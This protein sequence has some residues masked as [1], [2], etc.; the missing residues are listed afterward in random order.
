MVKLRRFLWL[1][2]V[3]VTLFAAL[4]ALIG[5]DLATS[6]QVWAAQDGTATPTPRVATAEE[7]AAA[8][9]VWA[10]S[11]HADTFDGGLGA[12]TTCARCKSPTNWDYE[13][14]SAELALDCASC[15][16]VPGQPRP[17]LEGGIP[18]PESEWHNIG[19][20]VCHEPAGDS[21][22]TSI[23][24]WNNAEKRYEPM[25]SVQEL[26]AQCHEGRHGFE[27][28][29]E[30]IASAVHADWECTR[31]HGPHG[32]SATCED[33]HDVTLGTAVED[34]LRHE[35][36]NC[37]ACHDSGQLAVVLDTDPASRFYGTYVTERYAHTLTSWPSHNLQ[38]EVDCRRCHHRPSTTKAPVATE[39]GCAG[40]GCHEEGAVLHWCPLFKRSPAPEAETKR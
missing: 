1:V 28:I 3:L 39:V 12:N 11:A 8:Q 30:Q 10:D 21:F 37:T 13:A 33:C 18:V 26:C 4:M 19:C 32:E 5:V 17:E 22:M 24:Y 23:A 31:C 40:S 20:E 9:A 38:L 16:R 15:K 25:E 27:V 35:N 34:H 14:P 29:E 7:L 36:V 2:I 6:A